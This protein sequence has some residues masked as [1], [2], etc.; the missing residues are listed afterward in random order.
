MTTIT[1]ECIR[2]KSR[3]RWMFII[4]LGF[5]F[6]FTATIFALDRTVAPGMVKFGR[7]IMETVP[8]TAVCVP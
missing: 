8:G 3:S 5:T 6:V 4:V 2:N 7:C 1:E